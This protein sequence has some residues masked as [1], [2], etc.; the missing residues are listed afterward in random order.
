MFEENLNM[1]YHLSGT[2]TKK[3][4]DLCLFWKVEV[5]YMVGDGFSRRIRWWLW[6]K[7]DLCLFG[8]WGVLYIVEDGF[9][10]RIQWWLYQKWIYT[11][12]GRWGGFYLVREWF[13]KESSVQWL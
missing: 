13:L 8:R 10:K 7:S 5:L 11:F 3:Q 9:S 4:V 1:D 12:F 6:L 2:G